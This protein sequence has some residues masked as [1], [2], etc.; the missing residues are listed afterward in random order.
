[1]WRITR[2]KK[3]E[4]G[5]AQYNSLLEANSSRKLTEHEQLE[6]SKMWRESD[7]FMLKKAQA[8]ALLNWR[9]YNIKSV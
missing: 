7:L 8:A 6:L 3:T 1:M 2:S 4:A 5:M 9:G